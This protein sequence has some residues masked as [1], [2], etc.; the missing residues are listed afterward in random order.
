MSISLSQSQIN[1]FR[2]LF[3]G[4]EDIYAVRWEKDGRSGYMPAYQF[5]WNE[6]MAH[7]AKGGTIRN[8]ENK[9]LLPLSDG[10]IHNHLQGQKTIG[11]Y[12]LLQDNRSCFVA[13]DFDG[14]NWAEESLRYLG[15]CEQNNIPVYLE[16]SRSGNGG[17]VWIFFEESYPAV[18]SRQIAFEMIRKV[19]GISEFQKDVSFDRLFPN[20][21]YLSKEGF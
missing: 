7:K 15:I 14:E 21:D 5:D 2:S 16:R 4:R 10:I 1:I 8:F 6:F 13:A 11:I 3:K 18:K 20:Q 12:P 9:T 19:F 17:H